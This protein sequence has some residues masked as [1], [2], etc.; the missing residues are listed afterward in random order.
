M[1]DHLT[2][3]PYRLY[4]RVGGRV[5]DDLLRTDRRWYLR[6]LKGRYISASVRAQ[7]PRYVKNR[8]ESAV[9]VLTSPNTFSAAADL[10]AVLK[11]YGIATL[12]DEETGGVRQSFGEAYGHRLPNSG[13]EFSVSGKRFYAPVPRPDDAQRGTVPDIVLT[14]ELLSSFAD[15]TDPVLAYTLDLIQK[16]HAPA[17]IVLRLPRT[18]G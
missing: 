17:T 1:I 5:S 15:D 8:F 14:E 12:I 9:C 16:R 6:L 18:G 4:S 13:V 11:D 2:A 7:A 3:K 10:A